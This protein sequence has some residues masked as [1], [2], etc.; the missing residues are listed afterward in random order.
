MVFIVYHVVSIMPDDVIG[1][2]IVSPLVGRVR[3][4]TCT[5]S[6]VTS[7][8]LPHVTLS[9]GRRLALPLLRTSHRLAVDL[10]RTILIVSLYGF[11]RFITTGVLILP[12]VVPGVQIWIFLWF[13][14]YFSFNTNG[15]GNLRDPESLIQYGSMYY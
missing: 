12:T 6:L 1:H 5:K 15:L 4:L 7:A 11:S 9:P 14:Y 2:I 8:C 10:G 3:L 13:L